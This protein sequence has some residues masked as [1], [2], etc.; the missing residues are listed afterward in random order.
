M[1]QKRSNRNKYKTSNKTK[2]NGNN[3]T[4]KQRSI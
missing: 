3:Q 4:I 1:D 2:I